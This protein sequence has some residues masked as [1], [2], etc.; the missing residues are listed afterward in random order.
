MLGVHGSPDIGMHRA[1]NTRHPNAN[2]IPDKINGAHESVPFVF[3]API[4]EI[5]GDQRLRQMFP[6]EF[7]D[8]IPHKPQHHP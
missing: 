8:K 4:L 3:S 2:G 5:N 1:K 6:L 7:K